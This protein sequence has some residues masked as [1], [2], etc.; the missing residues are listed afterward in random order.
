ML[1]KTTTPF[2]LVDRAPSRLARVLVGVSGVL[3]VVA[4]ML[5]LLAPRWFFENIGLF[6]PY[7]RHYEGDLGA[8]LLPLG[9]GLVYAARDPGRHR[10]LIAV[11]AFGSALHVLNHIF[12]GITQGFTWTHWL[13]DTAPLALSALLLVIAWRVSTR[14]GAK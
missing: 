8:F 9:A 5:L 6:P 10:L 3:F 12:D 1:R 14:Q 13:T 7:N 2:V 4:G 11:V